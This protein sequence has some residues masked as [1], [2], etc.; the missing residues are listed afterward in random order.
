LQRVSSTNGCLFIKFLYRVTFSNTD[1]I[2]RKQLE[3]TDKQTF[4]IRVIFQTL[5]Y[6]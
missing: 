6:I 4:I 5:K 3:L 1:K 2:I